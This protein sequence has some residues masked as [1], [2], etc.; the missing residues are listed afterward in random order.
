M[1]QPAQIDVDWVFAYGSLI[2]DPG[3]IAFSNSERARLYGYHRAFCI[4]SIHYRGTPEA[5]GLVLG[6]DHGG[7][8][9]GMARRLDP[10][11]RQRSLELL[12]ARENPVPADRVY[13]PRIVPLRLTDSDATV[14]ALAFIAD[15]DLPSYSVLPDEEV[16]E[17]LATRRGPRGPNRDYAINTWQ[18]LTRHGVHDRYL[19]RLI[20]RLQARD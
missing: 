8:C 11:R 2:W 13:L 17:H 7:S 18:A 16:V 6:L 3:E 12:Y 1:L 5:P 14:R 20:Q 15:R 19:G 9:L 4:Q 10:A